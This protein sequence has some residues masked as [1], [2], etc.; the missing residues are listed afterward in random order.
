MP[1]LCGNSMAESQ[2]CPQGLDRQINGE[3]TTKNKICGFQGGGAFGAEKKIV[4]NAV[5]RGKCHDNKI[6]KLQIVSSRNFVVIAQAPNNG[7]LL[8]QI[9]NL[10]SPLS[11]TRKSTY[12]IVVPRSELSGSQKRGDKGGDEGAKRGKRWDRA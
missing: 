12:I 2:K 7:N 6:L 10:P 11:K 1:L 9:P 3:T 8:A 4:Q 5:F